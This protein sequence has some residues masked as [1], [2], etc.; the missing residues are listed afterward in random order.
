MHTQTHN[1]Q[2][3]S[4]LLRHY[5]SGL[6]SKG[7]GMSFEGKFRGEIQISEPRLQKQIQFLT[8]F[9]YFL[10]PFLHMCMLPIEIKFPN[11]YNLS[12]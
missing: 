12:S 2:I 1:T 9:I 11:V 7:D 10:V 3:T 4:E 6:Q 8:M 5:H